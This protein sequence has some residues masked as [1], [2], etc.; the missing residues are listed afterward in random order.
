LRLSEKD[1]AAVRRQRKVGWLVSRGLPDYLFQ[2]DGIH[3]IGQ[4]D[5]HICSITIKSGIIGTNAGTIWEYPDKHGPTTIAKLTRE[6]E[7]DD[8]TIHRG[9]GWLAKE[10]KVTIE[11]VNRA[12]QF[13]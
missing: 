7:V 1:N 10:V 11:L 6:T 5:G 8:K 2:I 3:P 9:I 12:E 4:A 13:L